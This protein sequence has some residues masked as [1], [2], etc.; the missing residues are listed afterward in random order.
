MCRPPLLLDTLACDG[1]VVPG[2]FPSTSGPKLSA[3]SS[4][5]LADLVSQV[6]SGLA[7]LVSQL[8]SGLADLVSQL[9]SG[10]ADL[11]SQVKSGLADLV[12]QVKSGLADLVGQVKSELAYLVSQ[13]KSELADLVSQVK[14]ELADLVSEVKSE[15]IDSAVYPQTP[16]QLQIVFT[17]QWFN[18]K[19]YNKVIFANSWLLDSYIHADGVKGTCVQSLPF[20]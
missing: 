5:L 17:A 10:L 16:A 19:D 3:C 9:K 11:V 4:W 15:L 20:D 18:Y 2:V 12:G 1:Y 14:S 8:K 7:D 13:V 6:K